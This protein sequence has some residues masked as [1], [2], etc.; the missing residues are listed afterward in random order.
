MCT[1]VA[2]TL[3]VSTASI[4][5]DKAPI[6]P[7]AADR[8]LVVMVFDGGCHLWCDEVRPIISGVTK[9]YGDKVVLRELDVQKSALPDSLDKAKGLGVKSFVE[10]AMS[11]VPTIGVFT[12]DRKLIRS[13][14]GVGKG[15]TY[16]KYIERALKAG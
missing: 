16:K 14:P 3:T 1:A 13:I 15:D 11:L 4:A 7:D 5:A 10:G 2:L 8:V 9:Q 12:Q 6:A